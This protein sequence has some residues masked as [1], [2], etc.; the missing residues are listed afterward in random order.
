MASTAIQKSTRLT[1]HS[2]RIS[3]TS[4]IPNTT[5]SMMIAASTGLGRSENSGAST[6]SVRTTTTPVT[7]DA[8]G[9]RAPDESFSELADRLVDTGMPWNTPAPTLDMP[10]A[11][12]SWSTSDAVAVPSGEQPGVAGGLGEADEEQRHRGD[13]DRGRR[14]RARGRPAAAPGAGMPR[15]HLADGGDAVVRRDRTGAKPSSPPTTSTSAPGTLGATRASDHDDGQ[16]DD[17]DDERRPV[18]I[19]ERP[20]ASCRTPASCSC[21]RASCR[22][23]WGARR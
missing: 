18:D 8:I 17:P 13:G 6:S 9:V 4:I 20:A 7:I 15:G 23:A 3:R 1:R 16:R 12:I 2:R 10:W 22:S 5:A 11:T 14:G 19:A 21:R